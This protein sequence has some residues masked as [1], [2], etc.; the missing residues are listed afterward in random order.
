VKVSSIR[1]LLSGVLIMGVGTSYYGV[2][3]SQ[4]HTYSRED[5]HFDNDSGLEK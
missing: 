5:V 4:V 1:S 3:Y 2:S